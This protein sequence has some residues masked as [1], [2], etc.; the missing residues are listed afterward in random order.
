MC[1]LRAPLTLTAARPGADKSIWRMRPQS[2]TSASRRRDVT[3]IAAHLTLTLTRGRTRCC[4]GRTRCIASRP[5]YG[6]ACASHAGRGHRRTPGS[7]GQ[8]QRAASCP[9]GRRGW[10][11]RLLMRVLVRCAAQPSRPNSAS[12]PSQTPAALCPP[13]RTLADAGRAS[14]GVRGDGLVSRFYKIV[15]VVKAHQVRPASHTLP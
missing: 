2:V 9:P 4:L 8:T 7:T 15:A 14:S 11:R 3:A 10:V 12:H 5:H 6:A 13:L 1:P